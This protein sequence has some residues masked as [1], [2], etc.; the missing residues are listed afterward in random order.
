[1]FCLALYPILI[2]LFDSLE[3]NFLS[4][5]YIL[6]INPLSDS[7]FVKIFSQSVR[8]H[9]ILMTMSFALQKLCNFIRC[10]LSILY[11]R[12]QANDVLLR[13]FSPA[14]TCSRLF[15]TF[16]SISLSVSC[17]M[18]RS[19]FHLDLSFVQGDKNGSICILLHDDLQLNQHHL[20]GMLFFPLDGFSSFAKDQVTIGVWVHS[21]VFNSISLIYLPVSV[22]IQYSFF[23]NS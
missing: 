23:L 13:K 11:L 9:F 22:P 10:H 18:W 7:G 6:D 19:L 15:P 14:H 1:M 17:F 16:S 12:A 4:S 3:S 8:Y 20:L 21:W 5:L 2:G